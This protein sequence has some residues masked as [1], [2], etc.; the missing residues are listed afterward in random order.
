MCTYSVASTKYST[1]KESTLLCTNQCKYFLHSMPLSPSVPR[2][3]DSVSAITILCF[4]SDRL[5]PPASHLCPA[6]R[7]QEKVRWKEANKL[8]LAKPF[9]ERPS[10]KLVDAEMFGGLILARCTCC[11]K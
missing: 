8:D 7:M 1:R 9:Q 4:N 3:M 6:R 2:P 5:C 10:L 11:S